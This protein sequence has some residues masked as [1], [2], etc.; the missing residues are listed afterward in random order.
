[1][2]QQ[3]PRE[4]EESGLPQHPPRGGPEYP[5]QGQTPPPPERTTA[6]NQDERLWAMLCHLAAFGGFIIPIAG[7]VIGPFVVWQIKRDEYPLVDDQGKEA[8][9]FQLSLLLYG[10]IGFVLLILL[11]GFLVLAFVVVFDVVMVVI[12]AIQASSG[13]AYRYPL[14]IRFVK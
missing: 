10:L 13:K 14:C 3:P 6:G 8:L 2:S 11:I 9:N 12:A 4:P 1:M 7:S 5:P